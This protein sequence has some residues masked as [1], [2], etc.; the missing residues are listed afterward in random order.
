M[1]KKYISLVAVL[2]LL[3]SFSFALRAQNYGNEWINYSQS[4]Y[5]I[6]VGNDGVFR[7][8]Y[9]TLVSEGIPITTFDPRQ[10]QIFAKGVEQYI[11]VKGE[12]DGVFNSTDYIEFYA[13]ANDGWFDENMY[14]TPGDHPNPDYSFFNDSAAYFLTWTT[15]ISNRRLTV[16]TDKNFTGYTSETYVNYVSRQN[17]FSTYYT[18]KTDSQGITSSEYTNCEGWFDSPMTINTQYPGVPQSFNRSVESPYAYLSGPQAQIEMLILG[19]SNYDGLAPDHHMTISFAGQ[20]IDTLYEGYVPIK[21]KRT[22]SPASL[23]NPSTVFNFVLPNDLG[24]NA[25]RNGL[26]YIQIKYPRE[27]NMANNSTMQ[28]SA[29]D[30]TLSKAYFSFT[31]LNAPATDSCVVYDITNH[32]RI[33]TV[34]S[35]STLSFLVPNSASEKNLYITCENRITQVVDLF[36]VNTSLTSYAKFVDYSDAQYDDVDYIII[37]HKSMSAKVEEYANYRRSTGY[38]VLV[39]DIDVLYNEFSYGISKH[40]LAIRNFVRFGLTEFADT[41]HG[42]FLIGKSY[43]AGDSPYNYRT[44][45]TYSALTYVPSYGIPPSDIMLTSGILDS[46]YQPAIPTGR[47][48]ARTSTEI[49][50]YLEKMQDFEAAQNAPYNPA[51]PYEK[52]WMKKVLHFAGGSSYGESLMLLG[53]LNHYKDTLEG[54]YFGGSVSTFTKTSTAPIQQNTSDSLK[55]IINNGV[56]MLNFFGH[57]AGIGF[58]ISIDNPDEYSNYQKYPFLIANSCFAGDLYEPTYSSSEAFVIIEKKGMIGYLGSI[59]KSYASYLNVYSE[60]LISNIARKS[61]NEP[62]G[63]II[64]KTI[65]EIQ[66][67]GDANI[68]DVCYEMTL[69]GDPVLRLG[70]FPLPDY[71]LTPSEIYFTP[72]EISS[73]LDSFQL[74]VIAKNVGSSVFDSIVLEVQRIYPDNT[75]ETFQR[76]IPSPGYADTVM[77]SMYV[78]PLKG[79]GVNQF[80]VCLDAFDQVSESNESNNCANTSLLIKSSDII[81]VYPYNYA[82]IPDTFLTLIASTSGILGSSSDYIFEIDTTDSFD[83][84]FLVQSSAI[85]QQGGIVE[86]AL[87]FSMLNLG[88]SAVY[89]WRVSINGSGNWRESSFQYITN[90]RGWG[91]AHFFQLKNDEYEYV[92]YNKPARILEFVNNIVTISAQTGYY[93]FIQWAEEWYKIDNA[94]KGQWSC[95]SDIG[96]GMK[97]AVFDTVSITPWMNTDPNNDGLGPYD[98]LNCRNY[99]YY[100]FDFYTT[101]TM[102]MNRMV[103]FINAVPNGYYV[104]AFSHRNHNAE[105]YPEALY[106]AFESIG[107][108]LIRTIVNNR[109]YI[110]FGRKGSPGLAT[111]SVGAATTSIISEAFP[112]TTNW[113]QGYVES[114]TIGPAS[115]WNSLHWRVSSFE[116]GLWTDTVRLCVLGIKIDGSIDTVINNLPPVQDSLDILNLSS[117]IDASVYPYL[118]LHLKV[119]DDSLLT[120]AQLDRW[121]VL[122]EPVPET[123]ID[124]ISFYEF[125]SDTVQEG[126]IISLAIATRNIGAVDFPDSLLVSYWLIDRDRNIHSLLTHRT[127]MHPV[128]DILIDSVSFNTTNFYGNNSLWVEFNPVY[129]GTGQYDQLEQYHFNN[130]GEIKFYVAQD[131][132]NPMLD[133]TFDGVHILDGD[134]VSA[135]PTIQMMLKDE[136]KWLLMDDTSAFRVYLLR[137]GASDLERIYFYENMMENMIFYPAS[138]SQNNTCRIEYSGD[139]PVDGTYT[140]MVQARDK[141]DNESGSIDYQINFEVMNTPAITDILNWPNPFSTRTH[142]VFTLTGSEVPEYMMI[143]IMTITG[144]IVREIDKSE[145]GPIHIGRNITEYAWDGRDEYGDQLA[146]GVYLYRVVVKLNGAVMDKIETPAGQYFTKEF[147]KMV[148]MR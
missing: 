51:D 59:T 21:I 57:A 15:G 95:T 71:V 111:E 66:F 69:H 118:R 72:T 54:P 36:P 142:F 38:E 62:I 122:Y 31:G 53:Y 43:K 91:Q 58:D 84:P 28:F 79:I 114:T 134:I 19:E 126:E 17:Y 68:K 86:W 2:F 132:I 16:E 147:G 37:A 23:G 141:S 52:Q 33:L 119:Q 93:P 81:P 101:D 148:L 88:D 105:N 104:L 47:L 135:K 26:S 128:G 10:I 99:D 94:I 140:L 98:A 125:Y 89:F 35:G 146:N 41:I 110:I 55:T 30:G 29:G 11:Y 116:P 60:E 46:L 131:K 24:S 120:S 22:V 20:S 82:V 27:L 42:L 109:P 13:E 50:W 34:R 124:P 1:E 108:N 48:A 123:A 63:L 70:G 85:S 7:I 80:S 138:T 145:L 144:R 5:K 77:F 4:Y 6:R 40:P 100:D 75:S 96:N 32:R 127:K 107:S 8:N 9:S 137:P 65:A 117:R 83:S 73:E 74:Y 12:S 67:P 133:V 45:S 61:Y 143:Q 113:N 78:D 139:F 121:H 87:P 56:S 18:G 25:D 76:L 90:K 92:T 103:N 39:A 112:I 130:I 106:Q 129:S 64:Q 14:K 49:S 44:N 115:E 97:F 102:W 3:F 136:N